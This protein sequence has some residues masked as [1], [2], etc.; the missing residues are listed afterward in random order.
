MQATPAPGTARLSNGSFDVL[1]R[2]TPRFADADA[3]SLA[4]PNGDAADWLAAYRR[5]GARAPERVF[6]RFAVV[7]VDRAARRVFAAIDRFGIEPLCYRAT[8]DQF[9]FASRADAVPGASGEIAE[10]ALFDY[11]WFHVIPGPR[12]IFRDVCRLLPAHCL[13]YEGGRC[14]VSSYW[15]PEFVEDRVA[16]LPRLSAEFRSILRES[17]AASAAGTTPG[18]FLSGGTDSSTVAGMTSLVTGAPA[19]TY[20]IGFDVAGYDEMAYARTAARHFATD[21]HE[22]YVTP[23]DLVDNIPALAAHFDQPFG[24]SSALPAF[25]CARAARGDGVTAMLAGDG[26]DELFGGNSR[27]AKQRVFSIY[28]SVPR[29]LRTGVLEPAAGHRVLGRLPGLRKLASYVR[30]ASSPMP[31]RL[32]MYN[33]LLQIGLPSIFDPSFLERVD[34]EGPLAQQRSTYNSV[35]ACALINRMLAYDWKYT[36]ADTDLP[37]VVG[38]TTLAGVS[39]AFPLLDDRLV[40]FSLRLAPSLK[41]R[42]L[43]LRWFFKHALADF[44]P[45]PILAKKKHGFGLPFGPWVIGHERLREIALDSLSCFRRRRV[46]RPEFIDDLVERQLPAHPGYYGEMVW[47]VMMLEQWLQANRGAPREP[48]RSSG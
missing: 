43:K 31:D 48:A 39:V 38:A 14:T 30:Q 21:H 5:F 19:R 41:L 7:V 42:G 18:C 17:V 20:S 16:P 23:R 13:V 40:E 2:G 45:G 27:Y 3:A 29:T 34:T 8:A 26:G 28:Q 46:V 33:L 10:Q 15:R 6:G 25:C 44:L 24:N 1:C 22:Y 47:I 37:K 36:L 32:E 11:F 4:Q 35:A 9:A 12:T